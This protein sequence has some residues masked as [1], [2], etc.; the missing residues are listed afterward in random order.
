M[1]RV[2]LFFSIFRVCTILNAQTPEW[3]NPEIFGINKEPARATALPFGDMEQAKPALIPIRRITCRLT[4]FGNS[5]GKKNLPTNPQVFTEMVMTSVDGIIF[6]YPV[7]GNCRVS[8]FPFTRMFSIH[9]PKI[10][11][12]TL[13]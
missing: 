12:I 4:A 10:R 8:A 11:R 1:K 3:E 7:T 5:T 9:S 2:F 6:R 13:I